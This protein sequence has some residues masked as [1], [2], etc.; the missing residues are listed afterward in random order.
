[1]KKFVF[2]IP[3]FPVLLLI[4]TNPALAKIYKW[5]DESGKVHFTNDPAMVPEQFQ[6]K[7]Q[8]KNKTKNA[9]GG[10]TRDDL[11]GGYF[12]ELAKNWDIETRGSLRYKLIF[13]KKETAMN[14]VAHLMN[15]KTGDHLKNL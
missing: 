14:P 1:M 10:G 2:L 8:K 13:T 12:F 6:Q 7:E 4:V 9:D 3:I 15:L 5:T 11:G